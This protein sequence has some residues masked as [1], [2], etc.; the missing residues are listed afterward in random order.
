MT[1]I[2]KFFCVKISFFSHY[3]KRNKIPWPEILSRGK[4]F[5]YKEALSVSLNGT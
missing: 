4:D 2:R 1:R 5:Y 3:K